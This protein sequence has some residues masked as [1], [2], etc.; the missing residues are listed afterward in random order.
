MQRSQRRNDHETCRR[1]QEIGSVR[2]RVN[3]RSRRLPVLGDLH[4]RRPVVFRRGQARPGSAA[5]AVHPRYHRA[6]RA[7]DAIGVEPRNAAARPVSR[8]LL[9]APATATVAASSTLTR[10]SPKVSTA[11]AGRRPTRRASTPTT[12]ASPARTPSI[13]RAGP[14]S[15]RCGSSRGSSIPSAPS[16]STTHSVPTCRSTTSTPSRRDLAPIPIRSSSTGGTAAK[17]RAGHRC[18]LV[19]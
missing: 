1:T 7:A 6:Q 4:D 8:L 3:H 16:V 5:E 18:G 14:G 9:Q 10:R 13:P 15:A 19:R 2:P 17:R 11:S 12:T